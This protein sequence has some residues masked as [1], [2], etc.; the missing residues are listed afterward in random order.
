M[1]GPPACA[2]GSGRARRRR[3]D[4][5]VRLRARP[6]GTA[7]G[8]SGPPAVAV[9]DAPVRDP[10]PGPPGRGA[11]GTG[12]PAGHA[13]PAR[14][15]GH[16]EVALPVGAVH[17]D[18]LLGQPAE[19]PR[20]RM[21][22][23]VVRAHRDQCHPGAGGGEETAV[24][25]GAAVVRHLEHVGA[26]VDAAGDD[27]R[28]RLAPEV[29]GQQD[30]DAVAGDPD[31]EREVV[32]LGGRRRQ[33][34]GRCQDLHG[35]VPDRPAVAGDQ[36]RPPG[37]GPPGEPVQPTGPVVGRGEG[38]GGDGPDVPPGQRTREPSGVVGVEVGE[39]DQRQAV[40]AQSV[41]TAVDRADVRAGIDQDPLPR[42]G[43]HDER[44]ALPHVAG[45]QHRVG[46]RPPTGHLAD[47]PPQDDH[48]DEGG[49]RQ[50][51]RPGVAPEHPAESDQQ[52]R[53]QRRAPRPGGP[54]GRAV[55]ERRGP[56]GDD[57]QPADRPAGQPHEEVAGRR[58]DR[59]DERSSQPQ[60]GGGG[61]DG[62]DQQVR[63][64]RDG[65]DQ[66]RQ[67]GHQGRGDDAGSSRHR[68]GVGED[69]RP[70]ASPQAARPARREQ[71]DG[72]GGRHGERETRVPR[73]VRVD[74]QQHDDGGTQRGHG[75]P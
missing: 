27:P 68:H 61:H 13:P 45:D 23:R 18:P 7:G 30:P 31:D 12:A 15:P 55:R 8:S 16:G 66:S 36:D 41:Q 63:R 17:P 39:E 48:A 25:V 10:A 64:Q 6:V 4:G 21:A 26:Q 42:T 59:P 72:G 69:L 53:Q 43:R 73:Q 9:G 49:Q 19:D 38:A 54:G 1:T 44:V 57:D 62:R 60:H 14:V 52:D 2:G 46:R 24:G 75:D 40:D 28:L 71:D 67:A 34:R 35:R 22:V 47:G 70:A 50:G 3:E 56:L 29:P 51:P 11:G 5:A 74:E 37:T 65:T 58:P 32:G 33:F 20:R